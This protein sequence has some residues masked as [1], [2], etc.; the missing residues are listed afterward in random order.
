M[1]A[2]MGASPNDIF[3]HRQLNN[4]QKALNPDPRATNQLSAPN[5]RHAQLQV[6]LIQRR[7]RR[8][9]HLPASPNHL[10]HN[11]VPNL[12]PGPLL[13]QHEQ[14]QNEPLPAALQDLRH[15]H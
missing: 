4:N 1:P 9:N 8:R 11:D 14:V 2:Q 6:L 13:L 7:D 12:P 10:M 5:I 15:Q 3:Q